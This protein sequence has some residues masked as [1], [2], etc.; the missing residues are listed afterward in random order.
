MYAPIQGDAVFR[1]SESDLAAKVGRRDR[2]TRG[3]IVTR[4]LRSDF[5]GYIRV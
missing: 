3:R 2:G 4:K 1:L 5:S